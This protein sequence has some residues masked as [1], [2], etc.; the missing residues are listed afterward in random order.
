MRLVKKERERSMINR[1]KPL[2]DNR[3]K[4]GD[5]MDDLRLRS[6]NGASSGTQEE[7]NLTRLCQ[8]Q[9]GQTGQAVTD[10]SA[11]RAAGGPSFSVG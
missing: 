10:A 7:R 5:A 2:K 9:Q 4:T 11:P 3:E 1:G 8:Q 6:L